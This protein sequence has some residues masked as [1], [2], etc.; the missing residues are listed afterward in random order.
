ASSSAVVASKN[1]SAGPPILNVVYGASTTSR[2]TRSVPRERWSAAV[3]SRAPAVVA[4]MLAARNKHIAGQRR[5]DTATSTWRIHCSPLGALRASH[6]VNKFTI[7][8]QL[9]AALT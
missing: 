3:V 7:A 8:D 4:V 5:H 9:A 2:C 1:Q 6:L